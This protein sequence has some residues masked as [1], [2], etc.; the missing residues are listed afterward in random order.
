MSVKQS[1]HHRCAMFQTSHSVIHKLFHDKSAIFR[2]MFLCLIYTDKTKHTHI[3]SLSGYR[4]DD[5]KTKRL[6]A[7]PRTV[8]VYM[9]W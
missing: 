3:L 5:T 9:T 6:L 7:I 2:R 8:P 1:I 4:G